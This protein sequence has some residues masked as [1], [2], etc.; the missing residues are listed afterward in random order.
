VFGIKVVI[1]FDK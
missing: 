1:L